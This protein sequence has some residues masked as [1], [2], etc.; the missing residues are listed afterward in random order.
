MITVFIHKEFD[1]MYE[2]SKYSFEVVDNELERPAYCCG[3]RPNEKQIK[4]IKTLLGLV[5]VSAH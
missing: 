5:S 1:F 4:Q 2:C 3:P